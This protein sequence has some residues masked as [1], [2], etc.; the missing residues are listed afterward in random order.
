MLCRFGRERRKAYR[1]IA[2]LG[3]GTEGAVK[4]ALAVETRKQV[5][6]KSIVRPP[7]SPER[8]RDIRRRFLHIQAHAGH[9]F[10][11][12]YLEFFEVP[13][14]LYIV[15]EF[16][17]G[18]ELSGYVQG[19]GGRLGEDEA[20]KAV[21]ILLK[22]VAYVHRNSIVHRDLKPANVLLR[23]P[24]DIESLC[25]ADFGEAFVP[26][27]DPTCAMK[28][29]H[30][31]L[32]HSALTTIVGTP[33]YLAPEIVNGQ[34]YSHNVDI[35]SV[36]CMA[37]ELLEGRTPFATAP[38]F[39]ELF[40][41]IRSATFEPPRASPEAQDFVSRLLDPDPARRPSAV[42]ALKHPWITGS[43]DARSGNRLSGSEVFFRRFTGQIE[44]VSPTVE[45]K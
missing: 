26:C 7:K 25:V 34:P 38:S 19:K 4:L 8:E 6:L 1:D 15:T 44:L 17:A 35:W 41:R 10:I 37:Y 40:R 39:L 32:A 3:T 29:S 14:K 5:A 27:D 12:E 42:E 2:V 24:G 30:Y 45:T 20:R 31:T 36:G 11:C 22:A 33:F 18:G 23:K 16:C 13:D 43:G 28:H 9:P 21:E